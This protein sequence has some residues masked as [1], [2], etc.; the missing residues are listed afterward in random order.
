MKRK[1]NILMTKC[2]DPLVTF[3]QK[4]DNKLNKRHFEFK[5]FSVAITSL[6]LVPKN[7]SSKKRHLYM[8]IVKYHNIW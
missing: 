8:K 7:L 1:N 6:K 2:F 3:K 5:Y 4:I